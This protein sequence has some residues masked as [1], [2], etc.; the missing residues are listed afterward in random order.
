MKTYLFLAIIF[1]TLT[2][3]VYSEDKTDT[4]NNLIVPAKVKELE[5]EG[6]IK[7]DK[8]VCM[9]DNCKNNWPALKCADYDNRPK[10][11]SG[12]SYCDGIGKACASV[13]LGGQGTL[14][15]SE[16]SAAAAAGHKTRCCWIE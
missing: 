11:E 14:Y 13:T 16:C 2:F 4:T 1:I 7:A 3:L 6:Q 5:V 9:G 10:G 12:N 15:F 8:G